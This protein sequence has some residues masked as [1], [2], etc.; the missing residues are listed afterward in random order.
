[1]EVVTVDLRR[2][3]GILLVESAWHTVKLR[4]R[5]SSEYARNVFLFPVALQWLHYLQPTR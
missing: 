2:I 1:M 3:R 4:Q 5:E